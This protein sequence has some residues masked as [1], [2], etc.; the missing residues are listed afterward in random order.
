VQTVGDVGEVVSERFLQL[1]A[2]LA[3]LRSQGA[4]KTSVVEKNG[5]R[6]A[7]I[8]M[9]AAVIVFLVVSNSSLTTSTP[10]AKTTGSRAV[11]GNPESR[12]AAG[13]I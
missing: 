12:Y 6:S 8:F 7:I 3:W 9:C 1:N 13:L 10:A 5:R 11:Q 4:G 2:S